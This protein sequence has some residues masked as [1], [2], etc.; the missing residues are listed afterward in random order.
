MAEP[1]AVTAT[2]RD[3]IRQVYAETATA[4]QQVFAEDR[5][6]ATLELSRVRVC[7]GSEPVNRIDGGYVLLD[8]T[9]WLAQLAFGRT[10]PDSGEPSVDDPLRDGSAAIGRLPSQALQ[11]VGPSWS[12]RLAGDGIAT[13][14]AFARL[15]RDR[16]AGLVRR[17]RSR[18]VLAFFAKARLAMAPVPPLPRCQLAPRRPGELLLWTPEQVSRESGVLG[19]VAADSLLA[20]LAAL[21]AVLDDTV[22]DTLTIGDIF[23]F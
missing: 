6:K 7:C 8:G 23:S 14:G 4:V 10:D 20:Y 5:V 16:L 3:F 12:S 13:I 9:P 1:I 11:G 21:V 15:D 17:W 19:V 2:I 22:L 18:Q